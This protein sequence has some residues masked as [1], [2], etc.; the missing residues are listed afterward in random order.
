[1]HVC[2]WSDLL[3]ISAMIKAFEW[4]NVPVSSVCTVPK[5]AN[6]RRSTALG[7]SPLIWF[8]ARYQ[9]PSNPTVSGRAWLRRAE[10]KCARVCVLGVT[11][12]YLLLP[13][14]FPPPP[15]TVSGGGL[16]RIQVL[17]KSS[18]F[19][20]FQSLMMQLVKI[21]FLQKQVKKTKNKSPQKKKEKAV[22]V[23]IE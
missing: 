20:K 8:C 2:S 7:E 3:V 6:T 23:D 17:E 5:H 13:F 18:R 15:R 22:C 11:R 21:P 19:K 4:T 16:V 12:Q 10:R 14:E 1:M 9:I